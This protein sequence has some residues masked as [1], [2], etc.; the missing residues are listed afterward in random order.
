MY[1]LNG[2]VALVTGA[3]GERG[4][5]RAIVLR[6]ADEGA[7][8]VVNDLNIDEG[9]SVWRGVDSVVSELEERGS[10][11]MAVLA[12]VADAAQVDGMVARAMDRFGRIDILVNSAAS[13]PGRDRMSVVDLD[14]DAW[15]QVQR[16]NVKGTFL[17]C[18]AVA[19]RMIERGEGGKIVNI[20]STTGKQGVARMAAYSASK[21]AVI[22]FTQAL[23]L[24][25]AP[26]RVNVNA[27]C[28][29]M[30]DTDRVEHLAAAMRPEG[31]SA[32]DHHTRMLKERAARIPL[33]RVA[34]AADVAAMAAFL[35]SSQSDYLT[36]LAMNV[37]GGTDMR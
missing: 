7:A 24:E 20:S 33:G 31:V 36:G 28:P 37:S 9:D 2:K 21:A 14:E 19:R 13:R 34:E 8:V 27:I 5:G 29:G 17:C 4:I 15:D 18:R 10:D 11:A 1:D 30:V 26:H 12:D 23:A 16:V 3:G 22:A 32:E 25:V 35:A 6:L